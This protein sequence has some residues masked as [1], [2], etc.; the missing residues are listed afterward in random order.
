MKSATHGGADR[1]GPAATALLAWAVASAVAL[2]L[3]L[4]SYGGGFVSDDALY[5]T[6]NPL[7]GL[8]LLEAL[9]RLPAQ[10]IA[11]NWSPVHHGFVYVEWLAFGSSPLGYRIVNVLLHATAAVLLSYAALRGRLPQPA[12]ALAGALFLVH[13]VAVEAVAW[14]SQSKTLLALAL[15]LLCLERWLAHL[16]APARA[17]LWACWTAGTLALLAKPTALPLPAL[18]AVAAWTHGRGRGA[19]LADL[20]PLAAFAGVV[21]F[22]QLSAQAAEGGVAAWFGGSPLATLRIVPWLLWRY[23]RLTLLP[24]DLVYGVQPAPLEGWLEPRLLGPLAGL[25]IVAAL[26]AR[27]IARS[28]R[29]ALGVAWFLLFL[30][31]VLQLVPMINLFAD[32]YLYFALPGALVL[33][34]E[35]LGERL[36]A[37]RR[38]PALVSG[39]IIAAALLGFGAATLERAGRWANPLALYTEATQAYPFGRVGWTGLGAERMRRG[40]LDGAA[41][42]LLRS[43]AVHP[44]D[45]HVRAMLGEVRRQQGRFGKALYDF[46]EAERLSP[47]HVALE[48]FGPVRVT[49]GTHPFLEEIR[50]RAEELRREGYTPQPDDPATGV[51]RP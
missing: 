51:E 22:L 1:G 27:A 42:A 21:L 9:R 23:V 26:G 12:A 45:G 34:A 5:L 8:P 35:P 13:P 28:R 29:R 4:P 2:L 18:L 32:R 20:A 24:F 6:H 15:S 37:D 38:V 30:A 11:A 43:L 40:D 31:P 39:A 14:I 46:E 17:K 50:R 49:L 16:E 3:Y 7:V 48:P 25:A 44:P 33:F 41:Q 36:L 19:R 10:V 47:S